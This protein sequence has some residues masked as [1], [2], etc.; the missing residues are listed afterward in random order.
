VAW[1]RDPA[2]TGWW[3]Y[4][5]SV[6]DAGAAGVD[7]GPVTVSAWLPAGTLTPRR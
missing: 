7:D 5:V 2:D 6:V 1:R 3:G 4:V